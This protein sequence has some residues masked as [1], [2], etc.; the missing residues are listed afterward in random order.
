MK[1]YAIISC[2]RN[3]S[4]RPDLY[5]LEDT[6]NVDTIT[7]KLYI[8]LKAKFGPSNISFI[9]PNAPKNRILQKIDFVRDNL[10]SDGLLFFYFQGHGDSVDSQN[11]SL[12]AKDQFL[13]CASNTLIDN[14]ID[15]K[16]RGFLPSQRIFSIVDSCSSETVV[17]WKQY[18][19]SEYPQVIHIASALDRKIA[20]SNN[21][22]GVF[23]RYFVKRFISNEAYFNMSYESFIEDLK[24]LEIKT[25]LRKT[26]TVDD[27]F[28]SEKLFN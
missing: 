19:W 24:E 4:Y 10:D 22:A 15:A 23:S 11:P 2:V 25:Y 8:G 27:N 7:R 28:L 12:E 5:K 6:Y 20:P 14:T 21:G 18:P 9:S 1:R 17:E 26:R 16:I 3:T 13:V